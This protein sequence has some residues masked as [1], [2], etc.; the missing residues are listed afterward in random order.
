MP[1]D[2][3]LTD[4]RRKAET[5]PVTWFCVLERAREKHDFQRAAEAQR[6]LVRLGVHVKY[7]R[8]AEVVINGH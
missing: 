1:T 8:V 6:E 3:T 5:C 2:K 4:A 7:T